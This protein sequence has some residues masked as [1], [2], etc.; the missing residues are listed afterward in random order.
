MI[1]NLF[2]LVAWFVNIKISTPPLIFTLS[3][4]IPEN[5]RVIL[6]IKWENGE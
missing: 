2:N 1:T 5:L 4:V 6:Q 3:I